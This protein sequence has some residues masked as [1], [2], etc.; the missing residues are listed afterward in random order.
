MGQEKPRV[1]PHERAKLKLPKFVKHY[2]DRTGKA[3]FYFRRRGIKPVPL[4][5]LP[6]SPKFME[7]H[8]RA[9]AAATVP[10]VIGA[11]R[12]K[13]G[14]VDAALVAY[15]RSAD[16]C[17][18]LAASTQGW[19]RR[20]LEKFRANYGDL[21]LRKIERRHVQQ[22]MASIAAAGAQRNMGQALNHFFEYCV[23]TGL[24]GDNPAHGVKRAKLVKKAGGI[25]AWTEDD[26][27]AFEACHPVGSK[28]RLALA[29]YLNLGV[30][31]SDVVRIGPRHIKNGELADFQPQK[32][33]R[34]GGN[35]ITV[36]LLANTIAVLKATPVTGADTFL[37]NERGKPFTANGF[38]NKM[39]DWC[40]EAGLPDCSSHGLRKLCLIRLA[41]AGMTTDQIMAVSGHK[42]R[43]EIDTYV[44]AANRKRMARD[45]MAAMERQ[46]NDKVS[47]ATV[48]LDNS[49]QRF[50]DY[51]GKN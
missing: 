30:R 2:I 27:T 6:W 26:V 44:A 50:S 40:D 46:A 14:S 48:S 11:A 5:G 37:I 41:E 35:T 18:G 3:R 10:V 47:N 22:Y 1:R 8:A 43:A 25:R 17:D 9:M 19:R 23:S 32:T 15:Y 16:F 28:A 36:P 42:N 12:T 33:S 38:G 21:S 34:T 51:K 31:K 13:L 29:L 45:A 39:R 24:L 20:C 49:V 4:P 7:A